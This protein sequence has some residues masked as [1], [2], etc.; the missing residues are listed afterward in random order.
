MT[1]VISFML[2]GATVSGGKVR[3]Q[4]NIKMAKRNRTSTPNI[5]QETLERAR[6]QANRE[7]SSEAI[8]AA[9]PQ[10]VVERRSTPRRRAE[11]IIQPTGARARRSR[12]EELTTAMVEDML[13]HP[14]KLVS[15]AQLRAEYGFV[16]T[17]LRNMGILAACLFLT[18]I[19]LA[20]FFVR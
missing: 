1:V 15:E 14:T 7:D 19:G 16:L 2:T 9:S 4:D 12:T 8:P 6:Q 20:V 10:P 18:L 11:T 5:P 13:A 17:D 3:R